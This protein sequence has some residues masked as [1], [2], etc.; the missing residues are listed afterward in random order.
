M[1]SFTAVHEALH[2]NKTTHAQHLDQGEG[3][4]EVEMLRTKTLKRGFKDPCRA[5]FEQ[6]IARHAQLRIQER[7]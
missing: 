6:V 7:E 4:E 5:F 1:F 2:G 3:E